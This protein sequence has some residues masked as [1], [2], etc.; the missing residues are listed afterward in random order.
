MSTQFTKPFS[1]IVSRLFRR[2]LLIFSSQAK[3][4]ESRSSV[5]YYGLVQLLQRFSY[6]STGCL[7]SAI[8]SLLKI[9]S[10]TYILGLSKIVTIF[11]LLLSF[12]EQFDFF[13]FQKKI[14]L[15][16]AALK[17]HLSWIGW[18]RAPALKIY[19]YIIYM[20][21]IIFIIYYL[22]IY[23]FMIIKLLVLVNFINIVRYK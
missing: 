12:L 9:H 8:D 15:R 2:Y 19:I 22:I 6:I 1:L 11:I 14:T 20:Y 16:R 10:A 5:N 13:F 18:P 21:I 4:R 23:K 3:E 7:F 17:R